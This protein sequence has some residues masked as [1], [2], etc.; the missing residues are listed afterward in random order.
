M[1]EQTKEIVY[2]KLVSGEELIAYSIDMENASQLTNPLIIFSELEGGKLRS[3]FFPFMP[4]K[5]GNSVVMLRQSIQAVAIPSEGL[6]NQ[7]KTSIGEVV[8]E[9]PS[10]EIILPK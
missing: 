9:T 1:T 3:S 4:H 10:K 7:Y 6:V 8:I 2:L 5:D